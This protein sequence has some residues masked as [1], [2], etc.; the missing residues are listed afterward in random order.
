MRMRAIV[1]TRFGPPDVLQLQEVAKP[2]P[3]D[4]EVLI[5]IRATT[6]TAGDAQIRG[7]QV[8]IAFRL[9]L[10]IYAGL[11]RPKPLILGQDLAGEIEAVGKEVARFRVGDQIVGWTGFAL[12][13]EA[14]YICLPETGVLA[15]KPS[16]M[17]FEEAAALPVGG[18]EAAYFMRRGDIRRGQR[19]LI[20]GAGGT[21]GTFAIQ[22]AKYFGAEVTGVDSAEKVELL[23]SLGAEHVID[24]TRED[25]TKHGERYDVIFDVIGK[26]SFS[27]SLRSLT[28][29]GRY[30]LGNPRLF[31]RLRARRTSRRSGK[32][33]I[34][35][36]ARTASEYADDFR[37]LT[38]LVEA[39]KLRSVIDRSYP[40]ERT[41]EAHRY[42]DT[43]RKKGHVVITV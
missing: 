24:Y 25:F 37:F 39:G 32:K 40:L 34:P 5:R 20:Y 29:D 31:Q 28:N 41:A 36:A 16:K 17:S 27:R 6:V 30:L 2:T 33:V 18:L 4:N 12:G 7:L 42:V 23:R 8:P 1:L 14:E 26:T 13:A 22:L 11:I 38:E 3:K 15:L 10:R 43:G 19:V 21:I 35:W 9:P